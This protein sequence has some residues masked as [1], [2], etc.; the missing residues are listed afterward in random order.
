MLLLYRFR[1]KKLIPGVEGTFSLKR[2]S[3][4]RVSGIFLGI[5]ITGLVMVMVTLFARSGIFGLFPLNVRLIWLGIYGLVTIPAYYI[6][7]LEQDWITKLDQK[8]SR[9]VSSLHTLIGYIPFILMAILYLVLGSLSGLTGAVH[10][11][12]IIALVTV[13]GN[14]LRQ[15]SESYLFISI[16][17]SFVLYYLVLA[18]TALFAF[19]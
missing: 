4:I 14:I 6:S 1:K 9:V 2:Q 10:G 17:Q 15:I 18:Q 19:F 7:L 5:G 13:L 3:K 8:K 11:L 12:I 16:V